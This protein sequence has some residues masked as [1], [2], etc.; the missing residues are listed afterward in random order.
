MF[1]DNVR[2]AVFVVHMFVCFHGAVD[3]GP[4]CFLYLHD[5]QV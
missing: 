3:L 4:A 2:A 1:G 5:C